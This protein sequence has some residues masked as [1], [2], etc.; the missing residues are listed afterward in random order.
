MSYKF[1]RVTDYYN[2]FL[3]S[4]YSSNVVSGN[5]D[6]KT[7]YNQISNES[8]EIVSSYGK[9]FRLAGI[10]AMDIISNATPLLKLWAKEN[11]LSA[12]LSNDE[13]VMAQIKHFKP[14]VVWI[15]TTRFLNKKW[16]KELKNEVKTIKLLVGHI[17]A[18][19]NNVMEEGFRELDIVFTCAPCTV[20][21]LKQ[22]G[23]KNVELVYH[24]FDHSILNNSQLENNKFPKTDLLFTGSLITGFGLH[25]E[26]I[27]YLENIINYGIDMT[28]Y[29]NLEPYNRILMKKILS[30]MVKT[31]D[32]IGLDFIFDEVKFFNKKHAE[33]DIKQYSKKLL[34]KVYPAVFGIDMYKVLLKSNIC[35][36][37]HGDIAGKCAGNLR[38]FEA[39]GIG[40]CLLT[41][42]K[43]N[44]SDLFDLEKE[45][46]T[47]RSIDECIEKIK[48]LNNNP[49]EM[50]SIAKAGQ[51]KT[52]KHHTIEKRVEFINK[53]FE[54]N[55]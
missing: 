45:V 19:Y 11:N 32:K 25:N 30:G 41:D 35:F 20:D 46:V 27:A 13:I 47:Y 12:D 6:Y 39:T 5:S 50:K 26:R 42:W 10:D 9:Y 15:D 52:L 36:N 48:W 28:I 1:I 14:D 37:I 16:L 43:Q 18:P 49:E 7:Q 17:C 21:N 3:K 22:K 40:T 33:V 4:F 54:K 24:A 23:V 34:K 31:L 44:M 38:L 53:V 8:T 2:E 29:G 51:E 55:I